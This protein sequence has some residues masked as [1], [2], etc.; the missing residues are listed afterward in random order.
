MGLRIATNVSS[1]AAQR[2]MALSSRETERAMKQLSSGNRFVDVTEG[3]ADYAIGEHLRAQTKGLKAAKD[4]SETALSFLQVAEG[5]LN[6]QNNLLIRM[7]ELAVQSASDTYSDDERGMMDMEFQQLSKEVDRIANTT[8]YGS[9]KLL[10]GQ[11]KEYQFQVGAYKGD[12]NVVKY[13]ANTNTTTASMGVDGLDVT[14]R[15]NALDTLDKIDT[16]LTQ[17]GTARA[18]FSAIQ[19]RMN[20]VIS[21]TEDQVFALETARSR[22]EDVDVA[23]AYAKVTKGQVLQQYQIASLAMA[24]RNT[25]NLVR[26]IA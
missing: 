22:I 8:S 17:I 19:A 18:S 9:Q 11:D 3:A 12:D 1:L 21:S 15:D 6:E 7:R 5:G 25:E 10:A 14:S 26:L 16:A 2:A 4:N 13:S 20:S 23:E 24:N